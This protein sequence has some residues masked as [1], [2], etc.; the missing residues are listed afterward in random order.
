MEASQVSRAELLPSSD[1]LISSFTSTVSWT[2]QLGVKHSGGTPIGERMEIR[3]LW[4]LGE[5]RRNSPPGEKATLVMESRA[6][7][8]P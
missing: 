3:P 1:S 7:L 6:V 4:T 2:S 8:R 5:A